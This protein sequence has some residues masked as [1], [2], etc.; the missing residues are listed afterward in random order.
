[1]RRQLLYI[2][3]DD[4]EPG[5]FDNDDHLPPLPLPSLDETLDRYY[6]SLLPFGSADQLRRSRALIDEFRTGVG[7]QLHATLEERSRTE[8]NWLERWWED[9]AYC[10][11]RTPIMPYTTMMG[12]FPADVAAGW[13]SPERGGY[14]RTL[15]RMAHS[16]AEFW[17]H[18]RHERM[19][20]ATNPSGSVTF[21]S[22]QL[23]RVYNTFRV[24][25]ERIDR[26]VGHF[27]TMRQ[28]AGERPECRPSPT[29]VFIGKGRL[30]A[31]NVLNAAGELKTEQEWLP[32]VEQIVAK[33]ESEQK[34]DYPVA[35]LTSD[36]R[37]SWAQ[38]RSA[39]L[40]SVLVFRRS[41]CTRLC[42]VNRALFDGMYN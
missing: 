7:R 19:R 29:V 6:Q 33:V 41:M 3:N 35:I 28:P 20:P 18:I 4:T 5:T 24:P 2:R 38:V 23:K 9:Y 17:D 11:D 12:T 31:V 14:V 39:F 10:T 37:T 1:M 42:C 13:P 34:A 36:D 16:S 8:R 21:S 22:F 15:A 40:V 27:R 32:T 30:F 26:I 25:G